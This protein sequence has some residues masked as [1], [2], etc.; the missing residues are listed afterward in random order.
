MAL[1]RMQYTHHP[2]VGKCDFD[3]TTYGDDYLSF[4][5]DQVLILY[6]TLDDGWALGKKDGCEEVGWF[7]FSFWTARPTV[8]ACGS[9]EQRSLQQSS[10]AAACSHTK[11]FTDSGS[12]SATDT[13]ETSSKWG[14]DAYVV[15]SA[16][17]GVRDKRDGGASVLDP[18][19]VNS[20]KN[21]QPF[22]TRECSNT[23]GVHSGLEITTERDTVRAA[24]ARTTSGCV[25]AAASSSTAAVATTTTGVKQPPDD[26][27][28]DNL[29]FNGDIDTV[30]FKVAQVTCTTGVE[31]DKGPTLSPT[32]LASGPANVDQHS[33]SP[34]ANSTASMAV[35]S[36]CPDWQALLGDGRNLRQNRNRVE[37]SAESQIMSSAPPPGLPTPGLWARSTPVSLP[38]TTSS[39]NINR[40]RPT[41]GMSDKWLQ[42]PLFFKER[43]HQ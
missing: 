13:Q 18:D 6:H 7:P 22:S 40:G 41:S 25:G 8:E 43:S 23:D 31:H 27:P 2:G 30:Q 3:G 10:W 17:A 38:S 42:N 37:H 16:C 36:P 33:A 14:S 19:R 12:E 15:S 21:D 26:K 34:Q 35:T 5:K 9:S 39:P 28:N 24:G 32:S 1:A 4:K 29:S 20:V 11:R